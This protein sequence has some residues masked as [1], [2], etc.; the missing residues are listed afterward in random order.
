MK[1][2]TVES[3]NLSRLYGAWWPHV[4]VDCHTTDGSIHAYDLTFDTAHTP[5]SGHPAPIEYARR[6]L[7]PSVADT[8]LRNHGRRGF[9]YGNYPD[10]NDPASGWETYPGLPRFGSHYRGLTGRLDVL[11]ETYSYLDFRARVETI[12]AYLL[13]IL[14]YVAA[15]ATEVMAVADA[16][17]DDTV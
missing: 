13:E 10:Q 14:R 16:A 12:Y 9:F 17:Q 11:L 15:N 1:Q 6:R 2:E 5:M 7:L 8:V 3:R 4:F